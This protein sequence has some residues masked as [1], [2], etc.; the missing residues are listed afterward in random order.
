[1]PASP[2]IRHA[3]FAQAFFNGLEGFRHSPSQLSTGELTRRRNTFKA[4]PSAPWLA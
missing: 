1:M 2:A 3:D 4:C